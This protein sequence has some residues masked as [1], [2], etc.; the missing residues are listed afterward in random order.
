MVC[1]LL[2]S[3]SAEYNERVKIFAHRGYWLD[4]EE[5][6]TISAI[7]RA[8][9]RGQSVELDTWKIDK[10]GTI[11]V[12]HDVGSPASNFSDV[13]ELWRSFPGQHLAI[14]IKCD[15]LAL[16]LAELMAK[17]LKHLR[18]YF[19]AF[20]MST[21]ERVIYERLNFPVACRASE[22]EPISLI[23]NCSRVWLDAF[24]SDWWLSVSES[25]LR[26]LLEKSIVVSPELH[27]RDARHVLE[28]V[29]Q[30][31]PFGICLDSLKYENE[32]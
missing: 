25:S 31:E 19:F 16:H 14:N 13:L 29:K 2:N 4:R 30:I 24:H 10:S 12:G 18:N 3:A 7:E 5:Q 20:D 32:L 22:Y 6:N 1:N 26:S 9:L 8:F 21:P 28:K 17:D 11:W 15:G 27:G 23:E